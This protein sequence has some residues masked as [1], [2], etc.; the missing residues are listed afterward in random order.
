MQQMQDRNIFGARGYM[1]FWHR[2]NVPV[3]FLI[4]LCGPVAV[5]AFR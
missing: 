2:P 3:F 5:V 4:S 1:P